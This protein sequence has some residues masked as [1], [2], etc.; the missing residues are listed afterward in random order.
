MNGKLLAVMVASLVCAHAQAGKLE[1]KQ[2][3]GGLDIAVMMQ[4]PDSPEAIKVTNKGA[5]VVACTGA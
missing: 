4:P 1:L 5:R 2:D 3:L